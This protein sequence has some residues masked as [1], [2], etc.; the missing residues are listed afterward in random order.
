MLYSKKAKSYAQ[1]HATPTPKPTAKPTPKPTAKPTAR[2]TSTPNLTRNYY[3]RLGSSG[4]R[5]ETLQRRLIE[6]GWLDGNVTGNYD[7]AT[8]AAVTA[9]QE[10]YKDL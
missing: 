9:F 1:A 5:V 10:Q 6:L 2:P 4:S 3:L 7:A 8:E